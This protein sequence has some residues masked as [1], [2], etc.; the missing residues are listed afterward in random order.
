MISQDVRKC[1]KCKHQFYRK[2]IKAK[3]CWDCELGN[4]KKK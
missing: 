2:D 4:D 3:I 1:D